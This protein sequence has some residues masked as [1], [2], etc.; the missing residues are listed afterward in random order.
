VAAAVLW[1]SSLAVAHLNTREA[2]LSGFENRLLDVRYRLVGPVRAAPDVVFVAIDDKT[3]ERDSTAANGRLLLAK[4][5][6]HIA[7]SGAHSLALDVLLADAGTA[8]DR[9]AL[10]SALGRLP[11]VIAA[12]ARFD[13]DGADVIWPQ[14]DFAAA[15]DLGLVNLETDATGTPRFVP[16]FLEIDGGILPSMALVAAVNLLGDEATI[17]AHSVS[18]GALEVP[19]DKN[20]YMPLRLLG[21]AGTVTTLSAAEL[22]TQPPD[23]TLSGKLVVLGYA[24]T[25]TGDLFTTPF[26]DKVPGAEIIATAISQMIGGP[27]LRHDHKTRIWDVGHAA[28]LAAVGL[29]LMLWTPLIR[30]LPLGVCV[31]LLSLAGTTF[32]FA[33]GL[34]VSAALP[35]A[36][37]MPPM[38]LAGV[39]SLAQDRRA[40]RQSEQS[41]TS[42]RRFQSPTLAR[43]IEQDPNYL[44]APQQ[45][46]LVV[47]FVDLTGFT[48][49]SQKLGS[50]GTRRLLQQFHRLT[51]EIV[52]THNGTVINYMG[53]G[54]LAVFG[55]QPT[56]DDRSDA[57]LALMSAK[58]LE[59]GLLALSV[60]QQCRPVT[61]R[62]GLHY[63]AVILSRLGAQNHQQVTVSGDT[64]NL[65]S[66]L[67]EVAKSQNAGIVATQA[68]AD[69]L[70][71]DAL[72][73]AAKTARVDVRGWTGHV[74]VV[75]WPHA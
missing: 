22:M 61:C 11:S 49:L 9:A 65:A 20:A 33:E 28:L 39:V 25:G 1:V 37:A 73:S 29:S 24:A 3:L 5:I 60:P 47:F 67:M 42:L 71:H 19:L 17:G 4:V 30:A 40:A 26:D 70:T 18:L 53:D 23:G 75:L 27:A 46:E 7:D 50:D 48:A 74:E 8:E 55:L 56:L 51:G 72:S 21:P 58:D 64:V 6:E 62:S 13:G 32:A 31:M 57:D 12:A 43:L 44:N 68:F 14:E 36:A 66:R 15:A 35:L 52:E 54:A 59:R 41:L 63:G 16:L 2:W 69:R 45:Q 34:W 10:A 38:M